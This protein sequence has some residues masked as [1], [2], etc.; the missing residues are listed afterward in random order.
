MVDFEKGA[1]PSTHKA[2]LKNQDGFIIIM[3]K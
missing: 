3:K 2:A 1:E